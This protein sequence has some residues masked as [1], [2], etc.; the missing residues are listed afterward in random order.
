MARWWHA[1]GE[2]DAGGQTLETMP[3]GLIELDTDWTIRIVNAAAERMVGSVRTELLDRSYWDA[4]PANVDNEFGRAYRRAVATREPQT[5]E[6]FYPEPLNQWFETQAV[7]TPQ[8]LWLYFS[9]VTAR[10]HAVERLAL[11]ARVSDEL[12]GTLDAPAAVGRLPRLLVPA[13]GSW[14]T[15]ALL[16]EDGSLRDA[17]GW[18]VDPA[19]TPLRPCRAQRRHR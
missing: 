3:I 12:A 16:A 7:P 14:A 18:H 6:A 11:L 9:E 17:G 4:F 19:R 1:D 10:R 8:G 15:V 2:D 5:V 13:L